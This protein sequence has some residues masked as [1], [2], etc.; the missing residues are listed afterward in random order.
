[1]TMEKFVLTPLKTYERLKKY[2]PDHQKI[3]QLLEADSKADTIAASQSDSHMKTIADAVNRRR[4]E[5]AR[6]NV[7]PPVQDLTSTATA[8]RADDFVEQP[9]DQQQ[10]Q[11]L[12][13]MDDQLQQ[14]QQQEPPTNDPPLNESHAQEQLVLP[15]REYILAK[16][17]KVKQFKIFEDG[18]VRLD[19]YTAAR[20]NIDEI[21]DFMLKSRSSMRKRAPVGTT[22]VYRALARLPKLNINKVSLREEVRIPIKDYI[23][24]WSEMVKQQHRRG[25]GAK[26]IFFK[27]LPAIV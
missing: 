22:I 2:D 16:L 25:G 21:L 14:Q 26:F 12:P 9:I 4:V 3:E 15:N 18:R 23:G 5:F 10:W 24:K 20:S 11:Q 19:K 7:F 13:P 17:A 1:M 8:A 27:Q 6:K